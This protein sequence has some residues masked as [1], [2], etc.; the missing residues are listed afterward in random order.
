M[1]D[2]SSLI[3]IIVSQLL[4]CFLCSVFNVLLCSLKVF[5][6]AAIIGVSILLPINFLGSQL[7]VDF[8]D[9]PNKSLDSFSI[10]NVNNGSNR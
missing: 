1:E 10:S 6:V 8:S 2:L 4:F 3:S 7:D 9:L 5:A